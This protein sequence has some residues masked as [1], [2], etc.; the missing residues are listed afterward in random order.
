MRLSSWVLEKHAQAVSS[1]TVS[2]AWQTL[3]RWREGH[4]TVVTMRLGPSTKVLKT[5][6]NMV[7]EA[8][9]NALTL[10]KHL[11]FKRD[12]HQITALTKTFSTNQFSAAKSWNRLCL[13][14]LLERLRSTHNRCHSHAQKIMQDNLRQTICEV[15]YK[16]RIIRAASLMILK[17][18]TPRNM[19]S[20]S[21]MVVEVIL[22]KAKRTTTVLSI[23]VKLGLASRLFPIRW[24]SN[25]SSG[26]LST[27]NHFSTALLIPLH[28]SIKR[29]WMSV[30]TQ[31]PHNY[32]TQNSLHLS[33]GIL[34]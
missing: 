27:A 24:S 6:C 7:R 20:H 30:V 26:G 4:R 34:R 17:K 3:L 8:A 33:K 18:S 29:W 21:T 12:A 25:W 13:L 31:W 19:L 2:A 28:S 9:T 14:L 5:V 16:A 22:Q 15:R 10:P 32:L 11:S 1:K 23:F